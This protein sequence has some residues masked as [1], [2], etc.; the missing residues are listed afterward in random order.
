MKKG[1]GVIDRLE[2]AGA[3]GSLPFGLN[4]SL[5]NHLLKQILANKVGTRARQEIRI[6]RH[7]FDGPSIDLFITPAGIVD[8]LPLFG[9]RRRIENDN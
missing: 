4:A 8:I 9:K 5:K 1:D 3:D 7:P 2:V 6:L